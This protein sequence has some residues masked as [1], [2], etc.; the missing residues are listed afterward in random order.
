MRNKKF[1]KELIVTFGFMIL[2]A[3][4]VVYDFLV[5]DGQKFPRINL[6][7]VTVW[8]MYFIWKKSF[9]KK[10]K[11]MYY[12]TLGFI[13]LS[14]YLASV[15]NFYGI[16]H[17]DKYLH[18][19]SGILIAL[20]GYVLFLH[21][22]GGREQPEVSPLAPVIFSIIFSIAAAG[23]WEIWEFTTDS[24]FGLNAQNGSLFDTMTDIICGTIMGIITN[25]PIYLKS[26]GKN[27]KFIEA[28]L[29]EFE[30]N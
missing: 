22:C 5:K 11:I 4:T 20:I 25:I 30:N 1:S 2:L 27:I 23:V 26:K 9:L 17:Y 10:S 18:L 21:L 15:W 24:L 19:G 16:P 28:I 3:L 14:M 29:N 12:C 7:V 6:I 13:F 8:A